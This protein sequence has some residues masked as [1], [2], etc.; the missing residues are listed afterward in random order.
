[1]TTY[2]GKLFCVWHSAENDWQL[3]MSSGSEFKIC[4]PAT[5]NARSLTVLRRAG[6]TS[7]QLNSSS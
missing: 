4:G 6:R 3:V 1:M 2:T 7:S 5:E